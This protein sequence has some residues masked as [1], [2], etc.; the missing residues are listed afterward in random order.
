ME[1]SVMFS[2][3]WVYGVRSVYLPK[4]PDESHFTH[5]IAI[6]FSEM[7]FAGLLRRRASSARGRLL[8]CCR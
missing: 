6:L 4:S 1:K 7:E 8:S 2:A 3:R 5:I